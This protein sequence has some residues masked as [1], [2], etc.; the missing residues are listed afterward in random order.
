[1]VTKG[2][3]MGPGDE[4]KPRK[5]T[6]PK[7]PGHELGP[8]QQKLVRALPTAGSVAEAGRL[9]GYSS[10]HAAHRAVKTIRRNAVEIL[11]EIG[12]GQTKALQDL[13]EMADY[14]MTKFWADKGIVLTEK[15]VS[16]NEVR[17]K[18]RIELNKIHGHYPAGSDNGN[19][20]GSQSEGFAVRIFVGD[21]ETA[22]GFAALFAARGTPNL[23]VD[24]GEKVDEDVG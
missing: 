17:L 16:D 7:G 6:V 2:N 12:Y 10:R 23:I 13:R 18:A 5:A 14:T 1:M 4:P 21:A 15:E 8:K 20:N 3:S 24:V 22:R 19:S 11:D 9:A